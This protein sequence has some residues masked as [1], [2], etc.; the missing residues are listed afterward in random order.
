MEGGGRG[1]DRGEIK[2]RGGKLMEGKGV[3][4]L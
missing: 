3:T 4:L 2:G 1:E